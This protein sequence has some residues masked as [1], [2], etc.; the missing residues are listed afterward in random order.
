MLARE[1]SDDRARA[2]LAAMAQIWLD[3]AEIIKISEH[4]TL[5]PLALAAAYW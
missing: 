1:N 5:W 4:R 2:S 3:L